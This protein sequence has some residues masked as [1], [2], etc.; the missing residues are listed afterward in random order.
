MFNSVV[1]V[2]SDSPLESLHWR[3]DHRKVN[4]LNWHTFP[5]QRF[6]SFNALFAK[7][8]SDKRP[9]PTHRKN[10]YIRPGCSSRSSYLQVVG[11][12]SD[13]FERFK[14]I[15]KDVNAIRMTR[16]SNVFIHRSLQNSGLFD[17]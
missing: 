3:R 10:R 17:F 7:R 6:S 8:V 5:W 14:R 13:A 1:G 11:M 4:Q 12:F 16:N 15:R 2:N 9:N